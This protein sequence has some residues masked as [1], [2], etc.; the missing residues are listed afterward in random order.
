MTGFIRGLF[1][2]T[3]KVDTPEISQVNVP[4]QPKQKAEAYYLSP[5]DAKTYGDIE[6]MRSSKSTR[7]TFPKAKFGT[8]NEFIQRISSMDKAT[9]GVGLTNADIAALNQTA[10]AEDV[11]ER[12]RTDT[13]M[14]MFRSM[15]REMRK[16]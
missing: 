3:P 10:Q 16:K 2:S 6:F 15:A 7:R 12:R 8:D 5:D 9:D 1:G 14:D 13:S 11:S 4:T